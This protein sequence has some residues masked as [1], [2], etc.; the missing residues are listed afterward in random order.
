[1]RVLIVGAGIAGSTLAYWL[2]RLGHQPTVVERAPELRRGGYLVDFWG[3][4]FDVAERM[5]IVPELRRSGY[6]LLEA[7]AVG[8]D[9]RRIASFEPSAFVGSGDRYVTIARSDL[10]SAVYG[11]LDGRVET[12]FDDTVE[13]IDDDG[14]RVHVTFRSGTRRDFDLVVGADGLHSRVR[15]LAFGPQER[16]ENHLGIVVAAFDVAGYRPRDEHVAVM[17]A[18]VGFQVLRLSLREDVTMFL[19]T[20]RDSGNVPLDS[21][22]EQQALLRRRLADAGW[23]TPAILDAMA[24]ARTFYFDRVSQIRMPSWSRGRVALVG[25]AAACPS[26]LAGQGSALA[27]VEAYVLAVELARTDGDHAAA[28]ARYHTRLA[29]LLR[30]KQ[31]AAKGLGLAFAPRNQVQLAVR[32]TVIRLL[33]LPRVPNLVM[34][35]S[36][37]DAV[38]LPALPVA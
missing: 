20:L 17:H 29:P 31:D 14:D 30:S 21:P 5:G 6:H 18:D 36:L 15:L 12:V 10:A 27:M 25:D 28:F 34:G 16:F 32:N 22:R 26:L 23:E 37:R 4:G 2:Q 3:A 13:A 9:G 11:A 8:R 19:V 38:E 24:E 33:G 7:R 1:M 35:R